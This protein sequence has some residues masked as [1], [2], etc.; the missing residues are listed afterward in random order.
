[1]MVMTIILVMMKCCDADDDD[2]GDGDED[3]NEGSGGDD[4]GDRDDDGGGDEVTIYIIVEYYF[5]QDL[6]ATG[7]AAPLGMAVKP[8]D[9]NCLIQES[10]SKSNVEHFR[11]CFLS[12]ERGF[13][14]ILYRQI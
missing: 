3:D 12:A 13:C 10:D 7:R 5:I 4:G 6:P 14:S 11:T 8:K 1:M 9:S 2:D